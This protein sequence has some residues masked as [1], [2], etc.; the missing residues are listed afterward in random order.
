MSILDIFRYKEY[1]STIYDLESEKSKLES[2]NLKINDQLTAL[3]NQVP[4]LNNTICDL[5]KRVCD[6]EQYIKL[7]LPNFELDLSS[8]PKTFETL[9]NIWMGC[10]HN[11]DHNDG[12][13]S[14]R[15]ERACEAR[16]TPLS[17]NRNFGT[18]KFRGIDSD[19]DTTLSKCN[20]HDFQ[21][22]FLPCKHMYRLAY[23]LDVFMLDDV[24][25]VPDPS[26]IM[27]ADDL[28]AIIQSLT[29][30]SSDI[31]SELKRHYS[32]A[33]SLS[34]IRQ[35]LDAG[36]VEICTNKFTVL[37]SLKRDELLNLLPSG[38]A[39]KR[40]SKKYEVIDFIISNHPEIIS[41]LEKLTVGIQLSPY[42]YHLRSYI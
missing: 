13:Q 37:D 10:W 12:G 39:L 40:N 31:L 7:R 11:I 19:Y 34:S 4:D 27:F 36:L 29:P 18:A 20:C 3:Q 26:K 30:R 1:Q 35:L 42:V 5:N 28:R 21:R 8:D 15:Q 22:H 32:I 25:Y 24:K 2:E 17:L 9:Q 16:Y 41:E 14:F 38:T 33:E 6:L 23:E